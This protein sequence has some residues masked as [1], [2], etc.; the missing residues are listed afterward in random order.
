[1]V[2]ITIPHY[3]DFGADRELVGN[4]LVRPEAWDALR[5][6]TTGP[7]A[8][9]DTPAGWEAIA[10][11]HPILGDRAEAIESLI[12]SRGGGSIAS[13]GVGG[14]SLEYWLSRRDPERR[15]L[16]GE[17]APDTVERLRTI[18][19]GAEVHHHDLLADPPLD[20]DWHLFHRI[21]TEFS[22]SQWRQVLENFRD[23]RVL[24]AASEVIGLRDAMRE[25]RRG[26]SRGST[27]SGRLRNRAA[28]EALWRRT[29]DSEPVAIADL[30]GWVLTPRP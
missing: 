4:D 15:L 25:L 1:M 7:F 5:T 13:Y 29:H 9:A 6:K 16:I 27:N 17:Y 14:A 24:V 10:K 19:S 28:F 26:M 8:I 2:R 21:D 3:F 12:D 30:Q 22:N 18:T 20:A 23:Q 11:A